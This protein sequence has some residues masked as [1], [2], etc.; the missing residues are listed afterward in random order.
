MN[1]VRRIVLT[2]QHQSSELPV[3]VP[4]CPLG[5]LVSSYLSKPSD[6]VGWLSLID[7]GGLT[8]KGCLSVWCLRVLPGR[9]W[10]SSR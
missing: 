8:A 10:V 6:R 1:V 4:S 2:S 5:S 9:A 3:H 7:P